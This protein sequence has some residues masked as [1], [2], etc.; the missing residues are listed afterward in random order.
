[1][2][3][4]LII[5]CLL[6]LSL[7]A[8]AQAT[9]TPPGTIRVPLQFQKDAFST[10]EYGGEMNR[11]FVFKKEPAYTDDNVIRGA[12]PC[13]TAFAVDVKG[14][15]LYIDA[16]GS[17]DLTDD[18]GN[19]YTSADS[20]ALEFENVRLPREK[21][22]GQEPA[23]VDLTFFGEDGFSHTFKSGWTGSVQLAG[24]D[25]SITIPDNF[26]QDEFGRWVRVNPAD[27]KEPITSPIGPKGFL[28]LADH[29]YAVNV[30][31]TD[32]TAV[33]VFR[34]ITENT[35]ET[36][37][38]VYV[39]EVNQ[40]T[41][42][43]EQNDLTSSIIFPD[44]KFR[45]PVGQYTVSKI[46]LKNENDLFSYTSSYPPTTFQVNQSASMLS[47]G[48]PLREIVEVKR[49]SNRLKFSYRLE[50]QGHEEYCL[51]QDEDVS[52]FGQ[53]QNAPALTVKQGDRVLLS[54]KFNIEYG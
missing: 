33:A 21:R 22:P 50:G 27:Q 23:I 13:G 37:I 9:E 17:M 48:P 8:R 2:R 54:D 6:A 28:A 52:P 49:V 39:M 12:L 7:S 30:E 10:Q 40:G 31:T 45:L 42:A 41:T 20:F 34:E 29:V 47:L 4:L 19:V 46:Y 36:S 11:D 26:M 53:T 43:Y 25:F 44:K 1:M 5:L 32:S 15:K 35:G 18:A 16:N 38:D 24:K 14:Q 51:V 3:T